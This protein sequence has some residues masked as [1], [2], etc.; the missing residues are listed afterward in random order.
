MKL[1]MFDIEI[2]SVR[3]PIIFAVAN[4]IVSIPIRTWRPIASIM[5]VATISYPTWTTGAVVSIIAALITT[6]EVILLPMVA[7]FVIPSISVLYE[8][9]VITSLITGI[10]QI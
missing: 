9:G 1:I 5:C 8:R 2:I 4:T 7:E 10:F 3:N 6:S